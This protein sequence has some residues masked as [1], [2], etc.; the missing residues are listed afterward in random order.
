M[1]IARPPHSVPSR[2]PAGTGTVA[3]PAHRADEQGYHRQGQHESPAAWAPPPPAEAAGRTSG[4]AYR[5]AGCVSGRRPQLGPSQPPRRPRLGPAQP[6]RTRVSVS[7]AW[8]AP[9]GLASSRRRPCR[10]NAECRRQRCAKNDKSQPHP[11]SRIGSRSSK[12]ASSFAAVGGPWAERLVGLTTDSKAPHLIIYPFPPAPQPNSSPPL[13]FVASFFQP[14]TPR[15]P[16]PLPSC[17]KAVMAAPGSRCDV[18]C[19]VRLN[20]IGACPRQA[21]PAG[22]APAAFAA[23]ANPPA[24]SPSRGRAG[25]RTRPAN[26]ARPA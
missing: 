25:T 4:L 1:S 16:V 10:V 6:P 20:R 8:S 7:H 21:I 14:W 26:P 19:G 2:R 5:P 18:R 23:T 9:W 12:T 22:T 17:S 13:P 11:A 24:S 15:S 3:R